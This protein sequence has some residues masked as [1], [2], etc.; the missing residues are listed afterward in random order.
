MKR[1]VGSLLLTFACLA[2][3]TCRADELA[4]TVDETAYAE[5]AVEAHYFVA[6]CSIYV[7]PADVLAFRRK[8]EGWVEG[9]PYE[10]AAW[11]AAD[12][13]WREGVAD[14]NRHRFDKAECGRLLADVLADLRYAEARLSK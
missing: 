4:P 13:Q 12:T 5:V 2:A 6:A 7:E 9:S 11:R 14:L 3:T 1:L 8:F 10:Q